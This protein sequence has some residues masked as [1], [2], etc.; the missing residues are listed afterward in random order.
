MLLV[1]SGVAIILYN[2]EDNIVFF[3]P[4]SK[5]LELQQAEAVEK[6][7]R[8]GSVRHYYNGKDFSQI[9]QKEIRVGGLVKNRS[10]ARLAGGITEFILTD[11][12][13]DI[14]IIYKGILPALFREG[15]GIVARGKFANGTMIANQ[16]LTKHDE[17]Y[18]PP[19]S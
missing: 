12:V 6:Q 5:I 2:L 10:V 16:L 1:G 8:V 4:P 14:K 9:L 13:A 11:N 19:S 7:G 17:N 15:Q 3:Y 18:R